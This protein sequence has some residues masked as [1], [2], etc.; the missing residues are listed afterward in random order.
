MKKL[1]TLLVLLSLNACVT[2]VATLS[3]LTVKTTTMHFDRNKGIYTIGEYYPLFGI[4]A[5]L[6]ESINNAFLRLSPEYDILVDAKISFVDKFFV[7]G[8]KVEAFAYKS[9]ELR[10]FMGEVG[11]NKWCNNKNALIRHEQQG[12]II[13]GQR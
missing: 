1:F 11:F 9:S 3:L 4:G 13:Q 10:A 2:P 5:S 8:F 12:D 6:E 7:N